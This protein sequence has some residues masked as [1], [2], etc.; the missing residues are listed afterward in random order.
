MSSSNFLHRVPLTASSLLDRLREL[1]A[2]RQ[3][4]ALSQALLQGEVAA[5]A[6][7][8]AAAAQHDPNVLAVL[9][10]EAKHLL[11]LAPPPPP[12]PAPL[13]FG[14]DFVIGAFDEDMGPMPA[15]MLGAPIEVSPPF[16][17]TDGSIAMAPFASL[18]EIPTLPFPEAAIAVPMA[19]QEYADW[20]QT[21]VHVPP[22]LSSASAP[23][24]FS[25][26]PPSSFCSPFFSPMDA[27]VG[28][29][30]D[31]WTSPTMFTAG[32][33]FASASSVPLIPPSLSFDEQYRMLLGDG[34]HSFD[35]PLFVAPP[36]SA[37]L[38]RQPSQTGKARVP[39]KAPEARFNPIA[40]ASGH[41]RQASVV[42]SLSSDIAV[43]PEL[44][45]LGRTSSTSKKRAVRRPIKDDASVIVVKNSEHVFAVHVQGTG[46]SDESSLTRLY[47]DNSSLDPLSPLGRAVVGEAYTAASFAL[48]CELNSVYTLYT[49]T[50]AQW[51]VS[52]TL[53]G[54]SIFPAVPVSHELQPPTTFLHF[55]PG[56]LVVVP[57]FPL[58]S[59]EF[60][61]LQ[62]CRSSH[63]GYPG[64]GAWTARYD[65][66]AGGGEKRRPARI[67]THFAKC[68]PADNADGEWSL[69]KLARLMKSGK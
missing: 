11:P 54:P 20:T 24:H 37:V 41:Q 46:K 43:S 62:Q 5:F 56:D 59:R 63:A 50:R 17:P 55:L 29:Y 31:S 65:D 39:T 66:E 64:D 6:Q 58:G 40:A 57:S 38:A 36:Q 2:D 18:D 25:S 3:R 12:P 21:A 48:D 61:R 49:A 19:P 22:S 69:M 67:F 1:E 51:T 26:S 42:S 28:S 10:A 23:S 47:L 27:S 9:Q 13:D 68:C 35:E 7:D 14:S 8:V 4:I 16:G 52:F 45:P 44:K 30:A 60:W 33:S 34:P 32:K 15:S 53:S